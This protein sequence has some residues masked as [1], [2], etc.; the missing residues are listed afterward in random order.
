MI[1]LDRFI[2][3]AEE[4][5]LIHELFEQIL[6]RSCA[7]AVNWP[8]HVTLA[9]IF[10]SQLKDRTL[11]AKILSVLSEAGF[12]PARL[13]LDVTE[14][15]FV[16]MISKARGKFW[17]RY[18]KGRRSDRPRQLRHRISS[19]YHLRNFRLDKIKIDRRFVETLGSQDSA[20]IVS[21]LIGLGHGLGLEIIADGVEES[22]RMSLLTSGCEQGAGL[23]DQ[24]G[25]VSRR[26]GGFLC[27]R[28]FVGEFRPVTPSAATG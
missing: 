13:E 27:E 15:A 2:P 16:P 21:A 8:A 23:P 22:Q 9:L 11:H 18:A 26:N 7:A 25:G 24:S 14:S 4:N 20:K 19:L 12:E 3:L 10:P 17:G 1:S 6:R 28:T 5:G